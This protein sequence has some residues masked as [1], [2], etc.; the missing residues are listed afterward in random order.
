M[1][2]FFRVVSKIAVS[3]TSVAVLAGVAWCVRTVVAAIPE[4]PVDR[5]CILTTVEVRQLLENCACER[6][7]Q[8]EV[9]DLV[10]RFDWHWATSGFGDDLSAQPALARF[11]HSLPGQFPLW[12]IAEY[13][14]G[15]SPYVRIRYVRIRFGR[16]T[17]YQNYQSVL[18]FPTG[19]DPSL[20]LSARQPPGTPPPERV[21]GNSYFWPT[22]WVEVRD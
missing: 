11:G 2:P 15:S 18:F 16:H 3:L 17:R 1:K 9:D 5:T 10:T 20:V 12:Q 22:T 21:T 8:A 4:D 13:E 7:I 14:A 6:E 19:V